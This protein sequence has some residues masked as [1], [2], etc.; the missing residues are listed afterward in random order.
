[1][2]TVST[3]LLSALEQPAWEKSNSYK[4]WDSRTEELRQGL[5]RNPPAHQAFQENILISPHQ[6]SIC[7]QQAPQS[8]A[9]LLSSKQ[10][11]T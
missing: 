7:P 10:V 11:G 3:N 8:T 4:G 5:L 1:M 2:F 6:Q 9:Q